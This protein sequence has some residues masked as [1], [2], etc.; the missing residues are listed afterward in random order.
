M[1]LYRGRFLFNLIHFAVVLLA[2]TC[3]RAT[4]AH[5]QTT[6]PPTLHVIAIDTTA[7]PQTV[8]TIG[9]S[10]WPVPLGSPT[11]SLSADGIPLAVQRDETRQQ[12][13]QIALAIDVNQLV[14]INQSSESSF[15]QL[16]RILLDLIEAESFDRNQ[17]WLAAYQL[18]GTNKPLVLQDWTQEPNQLLNS[19]VD[20]Q[21]T[22][23]TD[24]PLSTEALLETLTLLAESDVVDSSTIATRPKVLLLFST[25]ATLPDLASVIEAAHRQLVAIHVVELLADTTA[26]P[27]DDLR[28]LANDSGGYYTALT[29]PSDSAIIAEALKA[30]HMVRVLETRID[31]AA[32][33]SLKV[34]V[35]LPDNVVLE[36]TAEGAFADVTAMPMTIEVIEPAAEISWETLAKD[37]TSTTN[38]IRVLPIR[39]TFH[40]LDQPERT[41][42]Q[43]SY[44]LR[45]PASFAQQVIRTEPPFTDASFALPNLPE[46]SYYLE[47]RAL[48]ELGLEAGLN[49]VTLEFQGL[50][51]AE[52]APAAQNTDNAT[53]S[54][55]DTSDATTSDTA[56]SNATASDATT[57][58]TITSNATASD[59]AT[60]D[61]ATSNEIAS[62]E[63]NQSNAQPDNA[64]AAVALAPVADAAQS[65]PAA[66]DNALQLPGLL[67]AIPRS[68]LLWLLPVLVLLIGYLIYS[69]R[70][71]QRQQQ[72]PIPLRG[73]HFV[74]EEENSAHYTLQNK[75]AQRQAGGHFHLDNAQDATQR[76]SLRRDK[77]G[78]DTPLGPD[79]PVPVSAQ[80]DTN[81]EVNQRAFAP[82]QTGVGIFEWDTDTDV[83]DEITRRPYNIEDEEATFRPETVMRPTIGQLVRATGEPNLPKE[84]PIYYGLNTTSGEFRQTYI[85][86]HSQ[87]NT[88]VLNDK[89]I[90]RE[91]AVII[92]RDDQ[93]YLR[94]NG[95]TAGTF[96]NGKKLSPGEEL[97]LRH[98][99]LIGFGQIAYEVH[100]DIDDERTI[101]G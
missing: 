95:S 50:S 101:I 23:V 16:T 15:A 7:F 9:G 40:W 14:G 12:R 35:T 59:A 4:T 3:F 89:R 88:L 80:F 41:L 17:D 99:D 25:G 8:L 64:S 2:G 100:L 32:P 10:H 38:D 37:S 86:R 71:K 85:G 55:T 58:D 1:I 62:E 54:D 43:V 27:S 73:G 47:I 90:S 98:N 78:K 79:D 77:A 52:A 21:P 45:G 57:S 19:V 30:A 51:A 13:V 63:D 26:Q 72:S 70:H 93:L 18:H 46:G 61:A 94:D 28:T 96:L 83:E 65:E 36:A 6:P 33:Q 76:Y 84:L 81:K 22:A 68:F 69:D 24:V 53:T 92:Q 67:V 66:S 75:H 31:L 39:A 87:N 56:I 42:L 60:S 82:L 11:V 49:E 5:A 20:N 74:T 44:T 29:N 48:D 34:A 97:L 91:H